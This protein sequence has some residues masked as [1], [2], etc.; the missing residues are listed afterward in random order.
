MAFIDE[1]RNKSDMHETVEKEV[2]NEIIDDIFG[3]KVLLGQM[4]YGLGQVGFLQDSTIFSNF[5]VYQPYV[6]DLVKIL[7]SH[8]LL[9]RLMFLIP[10]LIVLS[11]HYPNCICLVNGFHIRHIKICI[12]LKSVYCFKI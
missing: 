12:V 2:I 5:A 9:S 3:N 4:S 11:V 1:L 7:S 10:F 6:L 8:S